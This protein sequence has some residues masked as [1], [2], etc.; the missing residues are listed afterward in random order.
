MRVG[1]VFLSIGTA[2]LP[3][4]RSRPHT[5]ILQKKDGGCVAANHPRDF[6]ASPPCCTELTLAIR[7]SSSIIDPVLG[8][9]FALPLFIPIPIPCLC[10]NH[11][12]ACRTSRPTA[13]MSPY[14]ISPVNK[15]RLHNGSSANRVHPRRPS[16]YRRPERPPT[17]DSFG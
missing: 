1:G 13:S 4:G 17:N 11:H 16:R 10:R 5:H 6:S 2:H 3:Q 12:L 15:Q 9:T 14:R 8:R 7:L